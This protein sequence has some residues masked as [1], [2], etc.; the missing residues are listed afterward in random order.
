MR[1][2]FFRQSLRIG[3][4]VL[5]CVIALFNQAATA[6]EL[7][8]ALIRYA[9]HD[10]ERAIE[11]LTPLADRGNAVAQMQ[12]GL[13]HARGEGVPRDDVAAIDW[14]TRAAEQGQSEAQFELGVMNRDGSGTPIDGKRAIYWFERA[15]EAGAPHAFNAIGEM[16]LGHPDIALDCEMALIWFF[17]GAQLDNAEA[18]YNVGMRYPSWSGNRAGRNRGLQVVRSCGGCG[19]RR[20]P[21][22][23]RQRTAGDRRAAHAP[24]SMAS[25]DRRTRLVTQSWLRIGICGDV[26]GKEQPQPTHRACPSQADSMTVAAGQQAGHST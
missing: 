2:G 6:D 26:Y 4:L 16:Y 17:R 7:T 21:Q 19:N 5:G 10:Y 13:I 23:S 12:L 8:D 22:Q 24:A 14:L 1:S 15:A 20:R 18:L 9:V 25:K 11:M 3:A